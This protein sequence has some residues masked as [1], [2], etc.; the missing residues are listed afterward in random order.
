MWGLLGYPTE[1]EEKK[2]MTPEEAEKAKELVAHG[3]DDDDDFKDA[4][5]DD[6][7]DNGKTFEVTD[8]ELKIIRAELATSFPDDCTYFSDSYILSVA[9]KPYS[10]D[11]NIRRPLEVSK[12]NETFCFFSPPKRNL[13]G[14]WFSLLKVV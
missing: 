3:T 10:K 14:C 2:A 7:V 12:L 4:L 6:V 5:E 11:P 8:E 9:S 1:E 13:W